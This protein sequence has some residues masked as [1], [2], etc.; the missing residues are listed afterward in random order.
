MIK[1]NSENICPGC[2]RQSDAATPVEGD[3]DIIPKEGDITICFYCGC[4]SDFNEDLSI[5]KIAPERLAL[6][7]LIDPE[8]YQMIIATRASIL[9]RQ[10]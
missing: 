1:T 4:I 3:G 6:F 8:S 5:K 2:N 7:E 10:N 9:L